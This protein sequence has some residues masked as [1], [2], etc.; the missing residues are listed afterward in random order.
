MASR[1]RITRT[2]RVLEDTFFK[3]AKA[4]GY[5][6][7][8]AY[9]LLEIQQKH[10]LI[11]PGGQVACESLGPLK[12]GGRVIGVD[13]QVGLCHFTLGNS[14]ADA[15]K[16]LELARTA[17]TIATG[18]EEAESLDPNMPWGRGVLKPGGSLVMKL[19][20]GTGTQ[21]FAAELRH[22]FTKVAWHRPKATRSESK[23]VFLLGLKRK[24]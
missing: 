5:V 22:D 23:E 10:K 1:A 24:Q 3:K 8:S 13:L 20:Q 9:K 12:K 14:V 15:Y 16:S 19:L 6:A 17:W 18:G 21:E 11:P 2:G 7:R 4:Q